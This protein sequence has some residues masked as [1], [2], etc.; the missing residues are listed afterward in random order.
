[1][2][3]KI[4]VTIILTIIFVS[5]SK[6]NNYYHLNKSNNVKLSKFDIPQYYKSK[7]DKISTIPSLLSFSLSKPLKFILT[8]IFGI[9]N[10]I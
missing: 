3:N 6:I 1:M 5:C 2:N 7:K 9:V 10:L 8:S 4:L